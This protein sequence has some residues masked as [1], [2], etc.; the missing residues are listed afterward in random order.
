MCDNNN[1]VIIHIGKC[2]GSTVISELKYNN[3][4]HKE[5]HISQV[6]YD[7]NC[8]YVIVIRNP[9]TRFIS[10]FNWRKYLVCDSKIK[11]NQFK[12]EKNILTKYKNVDN[13]CKDL[14]FNNK[15]F[16]GSPETC[17]YI[18]HLKEDIY[19]YLK[20]FIN[21]CPK[22]KIVGV[23]C[24]ETIK[25]NMKDIFNIDVIKHEKKNDSNTTITNESYKILKEY[26]KNDYIIIDQMYEYGWISDEQYSFLK[27]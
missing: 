27:L 23:I 2:S 22:N 1:L 15:I 7:P 11:E 6:K 17:N 26:L 3:I 18:H 9:I 25:K 8:K 10:A 16:N 19:Y 20:N 5:L 4:K 14:K 12:N 24:K 13:L 21:E